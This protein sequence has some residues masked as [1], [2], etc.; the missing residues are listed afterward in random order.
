MS[1]FI[2]D[3]ERAA[4]RGV[5]HLLP[6][7]WRAIVDLAAAPVPPTP[8][9]RI[10]APDDGAAQRLQQIEHIVVVMLENRSFDHMLGFL[11]LPEAL[12]GRAR[13]D[14]DGLAG[15]QVQRQL[16]RRHC[17]SDPPPRADRPSAARPRIP[18]TGRT[19]STSRSP[20]AR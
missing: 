19:R 14:V 6:A 17:L 12:G 1:D 20:A 9:G 2:G 3:A 10:P 5:A 11:S 4:L 8:A 16:G 7:K 15:P 13:S 18:T